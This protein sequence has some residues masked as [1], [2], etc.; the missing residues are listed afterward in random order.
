MS[1]QVR[2]T[3]QIVNQNPPFVIELVQ[4]QLQHLLPADAQA[5]R[6]FLQPTRT[7]RPG[8]AFLTLQGWL[9]RPHH[10]LGAP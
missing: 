10:Q 4:K 6:Q 2:L 9:R 8:V 5:G 3:K 7:S 1:S